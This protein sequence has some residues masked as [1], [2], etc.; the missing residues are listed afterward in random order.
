M[1]KKAYPNNRTQNAQKG[2][3]G[4]MAGSLSAAVAPILDVLKPSRKENVIGNMRP[5]QNAK[6]T[7]SNS[8]LY[9]PSDKP[10][11]TISREIEDKFIKMF[12]IIQEPWEMFKPKGRK[13]FISYPYI[14]YKFCEL[15]ELEYLLDYFPMLDFPNL[16]IPDKVWKQICG[17]LKWE[18]YPTE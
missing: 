5:Y 11:P 9:D 7:V 12:E 14:L 4:N 16:A 1:S 10:A 15:L 3:F 17:Y 18:F 8:Y 6:S 2:Y 13:N